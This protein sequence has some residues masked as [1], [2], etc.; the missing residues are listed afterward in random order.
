MFN[1]RTFLAL[2][3]PELYTPYERALRALAL[4]QY[5]EALDL[6]DRLLG[7]AALDDRR[8]A[9]ALSKRG[10]TLVHLGLPEQARE[11]F[12]AAL[13]IVPRHAPA[14]VN[15]GNLA[16]EAG[17]TALAIARY[18]EAV[19]CDRDYAAAHHNLGVAY[20]RLGRTAE[21]VREL[22]MAQRLE[23]RQPPR[24]PA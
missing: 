13:S 12:E 9:A 24:Q 11:A 20:K 17:D 14:L 5:D 10:V 2:F 6:F 15:L 18:R 3:R 19:E 7:D 22:R 16:F 8:R 4:H 23:G 21:A 1:L